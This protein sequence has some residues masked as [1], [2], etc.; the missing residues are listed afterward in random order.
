[1]TVITAS[2]LADD[3]SEEDHIQADA[4][5]QERAKA[6]VDPRSRSVVATDGGQEYEFPQLHIGDHVTDLEDS[7][8]TMLVVGLPSETAGE[9]EFREGTTVADA[10]PDYPVDDDVVL[11]VFPQRT[12]VAIDPLTKYSYPRSRLKLETEIHDRDDGEG[13]EA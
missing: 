4:L 6:T 9:Y 7:D 11:V 2:D 5:E 13:G 3:P 12:D 10:N 1:M 8:A